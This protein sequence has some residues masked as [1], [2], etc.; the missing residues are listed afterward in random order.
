MEPCPS[1]LT[2]GAAVQPLPEPPPPLDCSPLKSLSPAL[3]GLLLAGTPLAAKRDELGLAEVPYLEPE[4][5][6]PT[7]AEPPAAVNCSVL[8]GY[9]R[10]TEPEPVRRPSED[11]DDPEPEPELEPQTEP[12]PC[13]PP[14]DLSRTCRVCGVP[15]ETDRS[16][17][18]RAA[19]PLP[20]SGS[21]YL[22]FVGGLLESELEPGA[23]QR[24][25]RVCLDCHDLLVTI[26]ELEQRVVAMRSS[27]RSQFRAWWRAAGAADSRPE[28]RRRSARRA[29]ARQPPP[30]TDAPEPEL[31]A[32]EDYRPDRRRKVSD[33]V[34]TGT[35][36][37]G[38]V[39][40][41]C[42]FTLSHANL[43]H[44]QMSLVYVGV[45]VTIFPSIE[46]HGAAK[47]Q[48]PLV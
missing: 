14:A 7:P 37:G 45:L 21:A 31:A 2:A 3:H 9:L 10:R 1:Q 42:G 38:V 28:R 11:A 22:A 46:C 20:Y 30:L 4:T 17:P 48:L 26:D 12:A 36:M 29:A 18:L 15:V 43:A 39:G 32:D 16:R 35:G 6:I 23:L 40:K 41:E 24:L 47:R 8:L 33:A 5:L 19:E 13:P 25:E 34:N 44:F 27:V